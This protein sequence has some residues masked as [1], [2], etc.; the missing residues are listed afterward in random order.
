M[1]TVLCLES[2][3]NET[4]QLP[5]DPPVAVIDE[6]LPPQEREIEIVCARGHCK[7]YVIKA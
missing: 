1:S 6:Y 5:E 7:I 4:V 3:C 2:D